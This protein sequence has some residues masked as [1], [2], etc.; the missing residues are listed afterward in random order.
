MLRSRA[1]REETADRGDCCVSG[2]D[3]KVA[4]GR[5]RGG[6]SNK[7]RVEHVEEDEGG[8]VGQ[9]GN[10]CVLGTGSENGSLEAVVAS[11]IGLELE[12]VFR[13]VVGFL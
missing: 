12:G 7:A 6:G 10:G 5:G 8:M 9:A 4:D 3:A 11:M 13:T 1:S 2:Y